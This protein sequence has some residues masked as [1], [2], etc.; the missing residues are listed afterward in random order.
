[1]TLKHPKTKRTIKPPRAMYGDLTDREHSILEAHR[2]Q[3]AHVGPEDHEAF[4]IIVALLGL[5]PYAELQAAIAK[6]K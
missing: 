4:A 5:L 2:W 3:L 6:S 1:M